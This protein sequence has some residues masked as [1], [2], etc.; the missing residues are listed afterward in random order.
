MSTLNALRNRLVGLTA[1]GLFG[2][3]TL[4]ITQAAPQQ[5]GPASPPTAP[6]VDGEVEPPIQFVLLTDGRILSGEVQT[7]GNQ[8][9]VKQKGGSL[10]LTKRQLEG[11]FD[12]LAAIYRYKVDR[13]ADDDPEEHLKL[14]NW[15]ISQKLEAEA[16]A[17]L[18]QVLAMEPGNR[19]A[20]AQLFNLEASEA[21]QAQAKAVA[22]RRD[23]SVQRTSAD[24]GR[25]RAAPLGPPP[26]F[27]LPPAA[28]LKRY[29]E[30]ALTVHPELQRRCASCHHES[31]ALAFQLVRAATPRE[32][33]NEMLLRT[34]LESALA[35]I[36]RA[37][38]DRSPLLSAAVLPHQG[39]SILGSPNHPT[40]RAWTQWISGI[41]EPPMSPIASQAGGQGVHATGGFGSRR[42]AGS[43]A[44][45]SVADVPM[46]PS[47]LDAQVQAAA[48]KV[49]RQE[50][51][52]GQVRHPDV[53]GSAQFP[54]PGIPTTR[55]GLGAGTIPLPAVNPKA[56][57][58]SNA[59]SPQ[60][61]PPLPPGIIID[62]DADP[63]L[64]P[65]AD[66]RRPDPK[67]LYPAEFDK[68]K[69]AVKSRVNLDA[70]EQYMKPGA[71]SSQA[72]SSPAVPTPMPK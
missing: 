63:G 35:L 8:T 30:F 71:A 45:P 24:A 9:I 20:K 41:V 7:E 50:I 39:R 64:K 16:R 4:G 38:P 72:P 65:L 62:P 46:E 67:E 17:E 53:P 40:Y 47:V 68:K 18:K 21:R 3:V 33:M 26:I 52:T 14:A 34:N 2:L 60:G 59:G 6:A 32:Q 1:P 56:P 15:C 23:G 31:S 70:L 58:R 69:P 61:L 44:V 48:S 29:Q 28:T 12:S 42:A 49:R 22:P 13:I 51:D 5:L 43:M 57:A 25:N 19:Q 66:P 10:R 54:T 27:D 11:T 55:S 37:D 36:D